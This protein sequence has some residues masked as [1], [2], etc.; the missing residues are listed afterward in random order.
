MRTP[1]QQPDRVLWRARCI[2]RCTPGSGSGPG[3]RNSHNGY[4]RVPGRLSPTANTRNSRLHQRQ[5][6]GVRGR[7]HLHRPAISRGVD[8]PEHLLRGQVPR[9]VAAGPADAVLGP[10]LVQLWKDNYCVYGRTSCGKRHAG[11]VTTWPRSGCPAD[12]GRRHRRVRRGKRVRT[13]KPDPAPGAIPIWSSA[14]SPRLPPMRCG[15]PT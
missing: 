2:E 9:S 6:P 3:K 1:P 10:A 14:T 12:A 8:G 4:H 13:T 15:L 7:A 5:P 11:P